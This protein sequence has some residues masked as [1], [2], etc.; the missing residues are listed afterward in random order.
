MACAGGALSRD[1]GRRAHA[2]RQLRR[3]AADDPPALRRVSELDLLWHVARSAEGRWPATGAGNLSRDL[4]AGRFRDGLEQVPARRFRR[5]PAAEGS[6]AEIQRQLPPA[7]SRTRFGATTS[8]APTKDS[9][10]I[11]LVGSYAMDDGRYINNGW[12]Q[13][14]PD[15]ITKLTWDNAAMMSPAFAHQIGVKDGDLVQVTVTERRRNRHR[16]SRQVAGSDSPPK[17]PIQRELVIAAL[18]VPGHAENSVTIPLATDASTPDRSAKKRA[19]MPICS[20]PLPI[21]ISSSPTV[22]RSRACR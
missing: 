1:L 4:A 15:P 12:L 22:R 17:K 13:E 14:M 7:A 8:P 6:T 18:I 9:P 16:R 2:E 5:P 3:D 19:S 20:A 10:E 21:R 11:V